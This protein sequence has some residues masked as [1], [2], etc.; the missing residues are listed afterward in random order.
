M[1][2][3]I[4]ILQ[5]RHA[6]IV[7]SFEYGVPSAFSSF[8]V[9]F[10]KQ[11]IRFLSFFSLITSFLPLLPA[12]FIIGHRHIFPYF[13]QS[14]ICGLELFPGMRDPRNREIKAFFFAFLGTFLILTYFNEPCVAFQ[15]L[16]RT[17]VVS[18]A[19]AEFYGEVATHSTRLYADTTVHQ[20]LVET[21]KL[22]DLPSSLLPLPPPPDPSGNSEDDFFRSLRKYTPKPIQSWM[23]DS[24]FLRS[25]MDSL[26]WFAVPSILQEYPWALEDFLCLTGR[27]GGVA[28][29]LSNHS[30]GGGKMRLSAGGL[31]DKLQVRVERIPYGAD[32][33][34]YVHLI[35]AAQRDLVGTGTG[36]TSANSHL[37]DETVVIVHGGAWGSGFPDMYSL[38]AIPFLNEGYGRVAIVGYR[39]YP[40]ANV[41]GQ[42]C[43]V[44]A[45]IDSL[46]SSTTRITVIGHSS[47][48]H[49]LATAFLLGQ[50][51]RRNTIDAYIGMSG[52]YDIPSHYRWEISRGVDRISPLAPACGMS[53]GGWKK[54]SPFLLAQRRSII[55]EK[56]EEETRSMICQNFPA[57]TILIHGVM[58]T[59][60]PY[61]STQSFAEATGLEWLPLVDQVGHGDTISGLMFGG[62]SQKVVLDWMRTAQR[63]KSSCSSS[64]T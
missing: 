35:T 41:Q 13:H 50:L 64:S 27:N 16:P 5:T 2:I 53:L 40:S 47:G 28:R 10:T 51:P 57:S 55:E 63:G 30:S 37:Q 12:S 60:V 46:P 36:D 49:L 45:A 23:R 58:D 44:M 33:R 31:S 56:D 39:T 61:T 18:H 59:T 17:H 7:D 14:T 34:Q 21:G 4:S 9:F 22:S 29:W 43:D 24:G 48:S 20:D 54:V 8:A 62:P 6:W 25:V 11:R 26:V 15:V 3:N 32:R 52:V 38:A 19:C 42:V 1:F